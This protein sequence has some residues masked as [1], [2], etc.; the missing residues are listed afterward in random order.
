MKNSKQSHELIR[1]NEQTVK[2]SQ[3]HDANLQKNS[4]LY[5]Q[6]GLIVCL[7]AAFGLLELQFE[8]TIDNYS[9]TLPPRE[10][11][12]EMAV[13]DFEI[14]EEPK[15]EV[16]PKT[17]AK[18]VLLIDEPI[19]VDDDTHMKEALKI[20]TPEEMTPDV[21]FDDSKLDIDKPDEIVEVHFTR[22]E[23]VP[24]YPGCEK[25]KG[26][27]ARKKCM[28]DKITQLVQRKFNGSDIASNYG[29]S[30]KQMISVEF[31]I[32]KTGNVT[33]IKTRAPHPE[34]EAE[35]KR[36]VNKIPEMKPGK[37]RDKPVG[38]RYT[39][40]IIFMVE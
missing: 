17:E 9:E 29:L 32:D 18:K 39:L 31:L 25:T 19:I 37:Q 34:L 36:V 10:E 15:A 30:G 4:T 20:D 1:Q 13:K 23:E 21:P 38:V 7:L 14:Y 6:V 5:F 24:V 28:S 16:K 22:I 26:N 35:A 2:Q 3:K 27:D 8:N 33:N 40:P 11:T 12:F